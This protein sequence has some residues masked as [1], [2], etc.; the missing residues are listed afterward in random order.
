MLRISIKIIIVGIYVSLVRF[1]LLSHASITPQYEQLIAIDI[2]HSVQRY[3]ALSSSGVKEYDFNV[4]IA[5]MLQSE[6]ALRGYVNVVMV[7]K[8]GSDISLKERSGQINKTKADILISIHHDSVQPQYLKER[9]IDNKKY[10]YTTDY[11]GFSVFISKDNKNYHQALRLAKLV[12]ENFVINNFTPTLHHAEKIK[13]ENREL[14]DKMNG[15][16]NAN[17]AI[18]R[19]SDMP[20]ILLECGVIVNPEE[21]KLLNNIQ[22]Q[23][24]IVNS[25]A[26]AVDEY[27]AID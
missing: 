20:S 21:E 18:L 27:Y 11:R 1:V 7:N 17:F 25:I 5:N 2:G 8:N 12:G 22:Y 14:V 26:S 6:L 23:K 10:F 13:G 16:Y 15:V 24:K 4:N 19:T 3:G 9:I